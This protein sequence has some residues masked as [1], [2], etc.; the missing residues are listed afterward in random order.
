MP[1]L[2]II[3][4]NIS[5]DIFL[6]KIKDHGELMMKYQ[7]NLQFSSFQFHIFIIFVWK[8]LIDRVKF[9][10]MFS[11]LH[12]HIAFVN[13]YTKKNTNH[14]AYTFMMFNKF[15]TIYSIFYSLYRLVVMIPEPQSSLQ[16]VSELFLNKISK[17]FQ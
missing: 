5:I 4:N 17:I 8:N 14:S 2:F 1:N 15:S 12:C 13:E 11:I 16:K 9:K 7:E 3:P 6:L 10:V